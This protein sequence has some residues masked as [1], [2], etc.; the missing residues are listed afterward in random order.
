[1]SD[2]SQSSN[3]FTRVYYNYSS[4]DTLK[5]GTTGYLRIYLKSSTVPSGLK[6][7]LA[8]DDNSASITEATT[9]QTVIADGTWHIYEWQIDDPSQ[10]DAWVGGSNGQIDG[11]NTY[12][13]SIQF[14]C[15]DPN[16]GSTQYVVYIDNLE[17]GT[18]PLN[19]IS[20]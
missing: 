12:F 16:S 1:M 15:N 14:S 13:D 5:L 7:R 8:V 3:W 2:S 19:I 6:V 20:A 9:W 17:K 18:Q 10:W 11:P 4:N